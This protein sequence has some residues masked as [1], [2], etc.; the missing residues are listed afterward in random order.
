[1]LSVFQNSKRLE[2][3]NSRLLTLD[4]FVGPDGSTSQT[5]VLV[6][7]SRKRNYFSYVIIAP[8]GLAIPQVLQIVEALS[9]HAPEMLGQV[10]KRALRER[11]GR[12]YPETY[13]PKASAR[14]FFTRAKTTL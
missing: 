6:C 10:A 5:L 9:Q 11:I 7:I 12:S 14:R 2:T 13:E 1:M 8:G 4:S 3:L